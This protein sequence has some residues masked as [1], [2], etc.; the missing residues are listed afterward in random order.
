MLTFKEVVDL[1]HELFNNMPGVSETST[2]VFFPLDTHDRSATRSQGQISMESKMLL[3]SEH[4]STH[5]DAPYHCDPKG[6]S[7]ERYPLDKLVLP[8]HLLDFTA[9][10][11][12]EAITRQD[13]EAA[14]RR[15]GRPITPGTALIAWTGQDKNW[16]K[17]G[18]TKERPYVDRQ[19]AAWLVEQR[20][21]LFG[22]DLIGIDDPDD[23]RWTTHATFLQ[24]NLP[25]VQ[26]LCNLEA[27]QGKQFHFVALPLKIRGATGCPVR[28]V[29]LV[30]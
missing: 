28:A 30:V 5:F 27:L 19:T 9:K 16:G 8:G 7:V 21:A 15:S 26:Q 1:S 20:I 14:A 13:F 2:A 11:V 4:I 3:L 17:P 10:G 24:G 23:W 6:L 29:A 12:R 25:M 22:T 18:W